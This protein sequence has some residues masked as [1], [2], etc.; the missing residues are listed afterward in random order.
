VGP[1]LSRDQISDVWNVFHKLGLICFSNCV[2][3]LRASLIVNT[4]S[5]LG[6]I[7]ARASKSRKSLGATFKR[8]SSMPRQKTPSS[9][10]LRNLRLPLITFAS[11]LI[12][13]LR[14]PVTA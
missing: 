8:E 9:E 6:K 10:G 3:A 12:H 14:T 4:T 11:H 2:F 7:S 5:L 13:R 1:Q